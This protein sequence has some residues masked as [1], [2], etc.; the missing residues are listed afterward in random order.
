MQR[1]LWIAVF[2]L[3]AWLAGCHDMERQYS[4]DFGRSF[5]SVF[6]NQK[7]DPAAGEEDKPVTGQSGVVAAAAYK[8]YEEAKPESK[9]KPAPTILKFSSN[10]Q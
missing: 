2:V 10:S 3:A 1:F 5:H 8:R 6:E 4:W 7:L 9:D